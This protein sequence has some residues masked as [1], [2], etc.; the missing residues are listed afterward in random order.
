MD[1]VDNNYEVNLFN[2][3]KGYYNYIISSNHSEEKF[4]K[5]GKFRVVRSNREAFNTVANP[6]SLQTI[7]SNKQFYH[8]SEIRKLLNNL[9]LTGEEKLRYHKEEVTKDLIHY[10]WIM[11]ILVLLP[12]L[13]WLIRKNNG[14]I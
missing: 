12:F 6:N 4:V 7:S 2:L 8:L 10:K 11:I 13:E 1:Q 5:K 14:L 9:K 3:N